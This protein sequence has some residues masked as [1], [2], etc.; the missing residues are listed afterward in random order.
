M[1]EK[2]AYDALFGGDDLEPVA[3]T[4]VVEAP[5]EPVAE[6]APE[7]Q[8]EAPAR[9]AD[10]KFV[11]KAA[12]PSAE[13][14][15]AAEAGAVAAE[16]V[17][18]ALEPA[19]VAEP[20]APPGFVPVA[21][22]QELRRELQEIKAAQPKA[23]EA[24]PA[25][26]PDEFADPEGYAIWEREQ[27]TKTAAFER[28]FEVSEMLATD[29]FGEAETNAAK[30]WA[31]NRAQTDPDFKKR[32]GD[33]VHPFKTMITAYREDPQSRRDRLVAMLD[34]PE[35]VDAFL[36]QAEAGTSSLVTP[37]AAVNPVAPVAASPAAAPA[38]QLPRSLATESSAAGAGHVPMGDEPV[39][40]GIFE[41]R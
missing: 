23:P 13:P 24:A 35:K 17:E 16:P 18:A 7:P 20:V 32:V 38:K 12:E 21:A 22:L 5:Q 28:K 34:T 27:T 10:G 15:P 9:G 33:S 3:E 39:F 25:P 19:A 29:A 26:P 41:K 8:P 1:S 4:P 2:T 14:A 40:K 30:A 37:V 11:A 31:M 36:A 6:P